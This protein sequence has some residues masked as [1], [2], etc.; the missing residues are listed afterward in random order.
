VYFVG[1]R[2]VLPLKEAFKNRAPLYRQRESA[3]PAQPLEFPQ[4]VTLM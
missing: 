1:G 2:V 3:D 4:T